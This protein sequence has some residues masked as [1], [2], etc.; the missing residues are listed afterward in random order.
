MKRRQVVAAGIVALSTGCLGL[1]QD[2][3]DGDGVV[4]TDDYAPHDPDVQEKD[5]VND[6]T[7]TLAERDQTASAT[8][9]DE[10]TPTDSPTGTDSPTATDS[11]T[12]TNAPTGTDSPTPTDSATPTASPTATAGS[13]GEF[14]SHNATHSISGSDDYWTMKVESGVDFVLEYTVTNRRTARYDFDVF[15][16]D[17]QGF[18]DYRA[19]V[20]GA[21]TDPTPIGRASVENVKDSGSRT[22]NLSAG[23]YHFVVDNT[24]IGDAGDV[25]A[26]AT[27]R[28]HVALSTRRA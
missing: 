9:S 18:D 12:P 20:D 6:G 23:V 5:D 7:P 16:F 24:D 1:G 15:V 2:D 22:A 28:V 21:F 4:D 8:P 14:P 11:P 10:P 13:G 27:R 19:K 3:S 25:G 17:P 26:E